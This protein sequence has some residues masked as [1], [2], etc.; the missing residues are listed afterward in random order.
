MI[1]QYLWLLSFSK[2]HYF[3]KHLQESMCKIA[4]QRISVSF[5]EASQ[6]ATQISVSYLLHEIS[7]LLPKLM[8][9]WVLENFLPAV[10][11]Q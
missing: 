3:R 4:F 2:V 7:P 6:F 9:S 1:S 11:G 8:K 10:A 5:Q